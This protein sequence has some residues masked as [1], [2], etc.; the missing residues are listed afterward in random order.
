VTLAVAR[1]FGEVS[2]W[3]LTWAVQ[4]RGDDW[5]KVALDK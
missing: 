2:R 5:A 4:R 3:G 1:Q